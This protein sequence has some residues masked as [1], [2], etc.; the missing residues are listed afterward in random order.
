MTEAEAF[1]AIAL[2][3]VAADGKI[4]QDEASALRKALEHRH[5]FREMDQQVMGCLASDLMG[6]LER[7]GV[8]NLIDRALL[9]LSPDLQESALAVAA[10]L[11]YADRWIQPKEQAFLDYLVSEVNLSPGVNAASIVRAFEV[12][13]RDTLRD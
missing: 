1:A 6:S 3:A 13:H 8:R 5:L 4:R 12:F 9:K 10:N 11:V 2:A 7:D